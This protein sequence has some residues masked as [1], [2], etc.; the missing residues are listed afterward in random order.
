M[1]EYHDTEEA[2]SNCSTPGEG[3][4]PALVRALACV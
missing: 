2:A 3:R 1:V 4:D